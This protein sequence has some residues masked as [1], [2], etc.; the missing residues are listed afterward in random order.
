[1]DF[2][3][4]GAVLPFRIWVDGSVGSCVKRCIMKYRYYLVHR[5]SPREDAC[6]IIDRRAAWFVLVDC[7]KLLSENARSDMESRRRAFRVE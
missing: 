3:L 6:A 1:M 4:S 7:G 2:T 5:L